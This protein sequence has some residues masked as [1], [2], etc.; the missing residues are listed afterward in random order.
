VADAVGAVAV[1][2]VSR[3]GGC[4]VVIAVVGAAVWLGGAGAAELGDGMVALVTSAAIGARRCPSPPKLSTT[5]PISAASNSAPTIP[6]RVPRPR[7][8]CGR[9]G[10]P[11][12]RGRPAAPA[13]SPPVSACG[14]PYLTQTA[15]RVVRE[16]GRRPR[17]RP[18]GV[19]GVPFR[20][21]GTE[22]VSPASGLS[23]LFGCR[24]LVGPLG[25]I[26]VIRG[27]A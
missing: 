27:A 26:V 15:D 7:E 4:T 1:S 14:A 13:A 5:T 25:W 18:H 8:P 17:H 6:T 9:L 20:Q 23:L 24:G 10:R 3:G 2:P 19:T 22:A 16:T 12:G 21:C 11:L